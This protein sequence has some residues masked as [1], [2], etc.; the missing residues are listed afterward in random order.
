MTQNLLKLNDDKTDIIYMAS[1]YYVKSLK[2]PGL[3][4]G[5]S[6]ITPSGSVKDLGVIFDKFLNMNDQVTSVCRAA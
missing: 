3:H 2:T 4:I 5:E 1:S 6:C